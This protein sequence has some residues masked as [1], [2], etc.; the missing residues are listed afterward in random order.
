MRKSKYDQS[1]LSVQDSTSINRDDDISKIE[2][3][4]E[5]DTEFVNLTNQIEDIKAAIQDLKQIK[6]L[7]DDS[8]SALKESTR[9]LNATM[10]VSD[11]IS[12]AIYQAFVQVE[13]TVVNVKLSETDKSILDEYRHKLIK[14]EKKL[15]ETQIAELKTIQENHWKEVYKYVKSYS[16]LSLNGWIAKISVIGFWILYTYFCLTL[17]GWVIYSILFQ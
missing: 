3:R 6:T 14:D 7:V 16:G 11:N 15:F 13:D 10:K 8:M 4:V 2:N 9:T 17:G 5:F 12:N 1:S